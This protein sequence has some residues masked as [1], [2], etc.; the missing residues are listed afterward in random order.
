MVTLPV[1]GITAFTLGQCGERSRYIL[2]SPPYRTL[3]R[4]VC[5]RKILC[6][7]R[8][9]GDEYSIGMKIWWTASHLIYI[10]FNLPHT[11]SA[12]S[13]IHSWMH[14]NSRV[15]RLPASLES[16][17]CQDSA[18]LTAQTFLIDIDG[19]LSGAGD[20]CVAQARVMQLPSA[21]HWQ[22]SL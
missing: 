3:A 5:C 11:W 6:L 10:H 21:R 8:Q 13:C 15:T 12:K 19:R 4:A 2:N 17:V 22:P 16:L 20:V 9:I 1:C 18:N 14:V 7:S